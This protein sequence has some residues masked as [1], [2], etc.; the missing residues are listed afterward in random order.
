[1]IGLETESFSICS[2]N[3]FINEMVFQLYITHNCDNDILN[4]TSFE[5]VSF[6]QVPQKTSK[7][8]VSSRRV[9]RPGGGL[10]VPMY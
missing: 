9:N 1:M 3:H 7:Y 2:E 5:R 6:L 8:N 4:E 10:E